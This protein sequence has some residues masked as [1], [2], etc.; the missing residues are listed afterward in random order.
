MG[1][2]LSF[3]NPESASFA[4]PAPH[5]PERNVRTHLRGE[6]LHQRQHTLNGRRWE[7]KAEVL[8]TGLLIL[9]DAIDD[10]LRAAAKYTASSAIAKLHGGAKRH[11]QGTGIATRC[12]RLFLENPDLVPQLGWGQIGRGPLHDRLPAITQVSGAADRLR[13]VPA[14]PDGNPARLSR[15]G[16]TLQGIKLMKLSLE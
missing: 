16:F 1:S 4:L 2:Q 9:T 13:R 14:H 7:I 5:D 8:H 6:P 3:P 15:F 12:L 10:L 11:R